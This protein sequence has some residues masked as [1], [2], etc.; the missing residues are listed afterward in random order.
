M[1]FFLI[2]FTGLFLLLSA[3]DKATSLPQERSLEPLVS[4]S[5]SVPEPSGLA[6]AANGNSLWTVSDETGKVY[7][8]D[9][10]G[11]TLLTI[12]I[13]G[14]DLEGVATGPSADQLWVVEERQRELLK[15]DL[16]ASVLER[17]RLAVEQNEL[18]AGLEGV[19]YDARSGQLYLLN[20]HD[21]RLLLK[22]A[23]DGTIRNTQEIDYL[24]DL[25]GIDFDSTDSTLWLVSDESGR[26]VHCDTS[27]NKLESFTIDVEQA[28]GIAVNR[29]D[30]LIYIISD[31]GEKLYIYKTD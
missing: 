19:T 15:V 21:P 4:Y 7:R 5:V 17:H 29:A 22:T 3:C 23:T 26:I 14:E 8:M 28:E 2:I 13:E 24:K 27:G 11:Q 12:D 1:K 31:P 9:L 20:E 10:Q 18:N 30:S 16:S 6:L 25:S